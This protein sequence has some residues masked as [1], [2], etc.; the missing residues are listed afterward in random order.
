MR[1][2]NFS[3]ATHTLLLL[4]Y[5]YTTHL[6]Y[7]TIT[8]TATTNTLLCI[9]SSSRTRARIN[10]EGQRPS[11]GSQ[12]SWR[13]G[14]RRFLLLKKEERKRRRKKSRWSR[15]SEAG[16]WQRAKCNKS[17]LQIVAQA[18]NVGGRSF[19]GGVIE[20]PPLQPRAS[21]MCIDRRQPSPAPTVKSIPRRKKK[22]DQRLETTTFFTIILSVSLHL[23]TC[24]R[25]A[26]SFAFFP[27]RKSRKIKVRDCAKPV[28]VKSFLI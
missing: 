12:S 22:R 27:P 17:P 25:R 13:H 6:I 4:L 24:I 2:Y 9:P 14:L 7:N 16:H 19:F 26:S 10:A 3:S 11:L 21:S 23:R 18:L 1:L 28:S 15:E 8:T 5:Y 20:R